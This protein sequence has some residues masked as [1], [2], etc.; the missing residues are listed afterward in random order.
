MLPSSPKS[1]LSS[2]SR[3]NHD[4]FDTN[5]INT[6]SRTVHDEQGYNRRGTDGE[7]DLYY[8]LN[9]N[10]FD[11]T[12]PLGGS[13]NNNID[14]N[15]NGNNNNNEYMKIYDGTIDDEVRLG[16]QKE[17]FESSD[18]SQERLQENDSTDNTGTIEY[19][20]S[21]IIQ[22]QQQQR[23]QQQQEEQEQHFSNSN[24]ST[25]GLRRR[26]VS[27]Q[28]HH[29]DDD[30]DQQQ[31]EQEEQYFH[32]IHNTIQSHNYE[33]DENEVWRAYR[34]Q[35]QF[36]NRGQWWT[37]SKQ[38]AFNRWV[39]TFIIGITQAII[40]IVCN[41]ISKLLS[42]YKFNII[43]TIL[44]SSIII[45]NSTSSFTSSTNGSTNHSNTYDTYYNNDNDDDIIVPTTSDSTDTD[46]GSY[47]NNITIMQHNN[48]YNTWKAYIV[49][50][51]IQLLYSI[52]ASI[53][54]W[55]EPLCGGSGIPEIKCFLNGINIPRIARIKTLCCRVLGTI[56]SVAAGLPLGM[57]GPMVHSGAVVASS[58]S[59]GKTKLF[60]YYDISFSKT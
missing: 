27:N 50:V 43:Y 18:R 19:H 25:I 34:Q 49:F 57:E 1:P 39:I 24:S 53:F 6:T 26:H 54:V 21:R 5:I 40:A 3:P 48:G 36:T 55:I 58:I 12:T 35:I 13:N 31:H 29:Y 41:F 52:I 56:F 20:Q 23:Q 28:N 7:D 33:I 9:G 30:D 16:K 22:E 45:S 46:G 38:R 59:Q 15:K 47:G 11:T 4:E 37:T 44:S 42:A 10:G 32:S 14:T 8:S 51:S 60:N 2:P 17:E